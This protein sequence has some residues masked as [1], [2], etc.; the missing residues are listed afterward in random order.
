MPCSCGKGWA[1]WLLL[2]LPCLV[3]PLLVLQAEYRRLHGMYEE[4]KR[5]K[6]KEL[7]GLV[8]EQEAYVTRMGQV[9]TGRACGCWLCVS[10]RG[11]W[12]AGWLAGSV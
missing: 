6:I 4:L 11:G 12:L 1:L 10:F 9:R 5:Q 8:E 7:E 3:V 2:L